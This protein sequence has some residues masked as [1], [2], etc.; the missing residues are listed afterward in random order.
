[1]RFGDE[2]IHVAAMDLI[3]PG[4]AETIRALRGRAGAARF[5]RHLTREIVHLPD[6][7]GPEYS[8]RSGGLRHPGILMCRCFCR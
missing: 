7:E 8:W 1:M 3:S 6:V 5:A 4:A 2:L